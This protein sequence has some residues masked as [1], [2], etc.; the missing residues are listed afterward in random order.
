M[1][2]VMPAEAALGEEFMYVMDLQAVACV[3]D[4]VVTDIVPEGASYVRSDPPAKVDGRKL[5]WVFPEMDAGQ[6]R[7]IKVWIKAEKE[8][9][10]AS[11]AT[12]HALPRVCAQ[13]F[14]GKATIAITKTGPETAILGSDI[15]YNIVV[16]NK[17]TAVARNLVVVDELPDGLVAAGGQSHLS[18]NLGDLAP[19]ASKTLTVPAKAVKRGKFC[20]GAAVATANAG[21][22][23]AEACTT[24]LQPGL[25]IVKTGTKEQ[26]LNRVAKYTIVISNTGDTVLKNVVVTDTAPAPTAIVT[27]PGAVVTANTASW[28]VGD[29][30]PG[31]E[32]SFSINLTSQQAG[33]HCNSA[34]VA[35]DQGLRATSEACTIWRG[36]GAVLLEVVDDPDPIKVDDETVYTIRVTNQGTANLHNI[37]TTADFDVE[38]LPIATSVGQISGQKVTFPVVR[39]L[40]AKQSFSYTV[41][42][43]GVKVGD[44]HS[45]VTVVS[46]EIPRPVVEEE[47]TQVY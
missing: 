16:S 23:K 4:V 17:G 36:L 24:I 40:G 32:K 47:S 30:G 5:I 43:R 2:K 26:F 41:K 25:K 18:Y 15:A 38:T 46:D 14:V 42:V 6:T 1:T 9:T 27:A 7:Q 12:V 22:A 35:C 13:T 8:G 11:C 34:T 39:E 29:L 19:G 28:N 44:S 10:L 37:K 3:A 45:K 20:N 33:N 31:Q 21:E